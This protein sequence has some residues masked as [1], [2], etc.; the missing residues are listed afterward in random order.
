MILFIGAA[1]SESRLKSSPDDEVTHLTAGMSYLISH[2]IFRDNP[3]HP[4]LLKELSALSLWAGKVHWPRTPEADYLVRGDDPETV[5]R[6][7]NPVGV[8][9]LA[10]NGPERVRRW[11]RPPM[12]LIGALLVAVI[13]LWTRALFGGIAAVFATLVCAL[14]PI[15]LGH[16]QFVTTDVGVAAFTALALFLLWQYLSLPRWRTLIFTG[17]AFGAALSAK[18]SAIFLVPIAAVLLIAAVKWPVSEAAKTAR[19]RVRERSAAIA[20]LVICAVAFVFVQA[21]Y[22]FPQDL[23][24][25]WKCALTVDADHLPTDL[26][27]LFGEL[28]PSFPHYFLVAYLVKEP[29]ASILLAL[30]GLVFVVRSRSVPVLARVFLLLPPAVFFVAVSAMAA[31]IGVRYLTP[32]LVFCH[33]LAGV[34]FAALVSRRS[35]LSVGLAAALGVWLIF[36]AIGIYPDQ[37]S[38]YN[39][40]ACLLTEP[41]YLG[42]D[43]GSRCGVYWLDDSNGDWGQGYVELKNWM[44]RNAPGRIANATYTSFIPPDLLGLRLKRTLPAELLQPPKE[45][46]YVVSAYWVSRLMAQ[47]QTNWIQFTRPTAIVG[48]ALYVYDLQKP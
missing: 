34:G 15:V 2:Q 26:H 5:Y 33:M 42:R 39:E 17:L 30:I 22:F 40:A 1:F 35:R 8:Q 48:H 6:L 44:D 10:A 23:S 9:V 43:G 27:F 25:Y 7:P 11:A 36:A 14:D 12:I 13:F 20:F 18:F 46:L 45:G 24:I 31:N 41:R 47:S 28:R 32:V 29:I 4:P 3:Q 21:T 16:S 19:L 38:Y 37:L